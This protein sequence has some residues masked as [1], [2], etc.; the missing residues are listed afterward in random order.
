MLI[1]TLYILGGLVLGGV[2]G[3]LLSANR[4]RSKYE[5]VL[6]EI[7]DRASS[8]E[9]KSNALE[10]TVTE[11]RTQSEQLSRKAADDFEKLRA[12]LS[13]ETE[14]RVKAETEAKETVNRLVE[15]KKL[16]ADAKEKLTD[17]FK[18]LAGDTL[19]N[20]TSAF[21][22][23]AKETFETV[24][25]EAKGD[26]G[27]R[28]EAIQGLVKPL[29]ESLKQFEE[30]VRALEKNR[31]GAYSGIKQHLEDLAS[32]QQQLQKETGNLV[33]ALRS[34]Q[35]RGR[36]G[37]MTLRRVVELAGM[38]EHC[39]FS[40]QVGV[41]SDDGRL[42]PDM[43]VHLPAERDIVVDAKVSLD[44]YLKATSAES[45]DERKEFF[46]THAR[47]IRAHMKSLGGKAYWN[48][49]ES[50]PE[51][52]VMFIPGESFLAAAAHY[53]HDL[54]EDG[55]QMQVVLAT[56]TTLIAL[57]RAVAFGWRQEQI[58][59]NAQVVSDLGKLLYER[60][61]VLAGHISQ[62][63]NGLEKANSAYSKAVS[64]MESRV[65]SAARRF[66]DLGVASGDDIPT[67]EPIETTPRTLITPQ[68]SGDEENNE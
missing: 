63:G 10:G 37:E 32:V 27:Q 42:V 29:S 9:G 60:M 51:F 50:T 34:P 54:I 17:A 23:L 28:Q 30:H 48:Q 64:S 16:L 12:D 56:P 62:V 8:A 20:T 61:R 6:Q 52:V 15:E 5:Q 1:Y 47:Q 58:A 65:F 67:L 44:A 25:T 31:E 3:W 53:D 4:T 7:R 35:V 14:A 55:M 19:D 11:L 66:K 13:T 49:F 41:Q 57:L 18:S 59:K 46:A 40:E 39:D 21:L 33:S 26:L 43:I 38:S 45:E 36:W 22:K 2:V 24:L 68:I